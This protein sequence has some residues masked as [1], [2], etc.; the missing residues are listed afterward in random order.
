M[1]ILIINGSPKEDGN[2][3]TALKIVENELIRLHVNTNWIHLGKKSVHGC[4]QCG[5]CKKENR[6][7]FSDDICN[8]IID[9]IIQSDGVLI[10]SPVYYSG[11]NGSLCALLDRVFYATCCPRDSSLRSSAWTQL[12]ANKIGGAIVT[13][14][15]TEGSSALDRI[16]KYF[17]ASQMKI[18]SSSDFLVFPEINNAITEQDR[19]ILASLGQNMAK[20]LTIQ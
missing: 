16:H 14:Y 2:T 17:F 10:G 1:K 11:A 6:C 3:S 9:G 18:A 15:P 5:F 12:F 8:D 19:N 20:M 7:V 4:I 13:Q